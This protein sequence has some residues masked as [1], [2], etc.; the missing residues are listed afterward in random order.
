MELKRLKYFVVKILNEA[1]RLQ[2]INLKG[3]LISKRKISNTKIV[4]FLISLAC[5]FVLR[6]GFTDN[7]SGFTISFLGIFIGLFASVVVSLHDKSKKLI[8]GLA[9][10]PDL[11]KARN[12]KLKNYMIQFTGLTA[13]SII[14]GL[15]L[16][17]LLSIVLLTDSSK[18]DIFRYHFIKSIDQVSIV[19][20]WNF[21]KV[22]LLII[23]RILVLYLLLRFFTVTI[24]A[25]ASYFSFLISD[26]RSMKIKHPQEF[27]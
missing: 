23:H 15:F 6:T 4:S 14:V 27:L 16:A 22:S 13:Y 24:Y 2:N 3:E 20:I 7:F 18:V 25:V 26:Y 11:E 1:D 12:I 19:T 5:L 21:I 17:L 10:M 9:T 8:E